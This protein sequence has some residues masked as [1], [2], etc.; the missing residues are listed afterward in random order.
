MPIGKRTKLIVRIMI[1]IILGIAISD[2]NQAMVSM[3]TNALAS[4]AGQVGVHL[5]DVEVGATIL[6]LCP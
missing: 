4:F 1:V 5:A 3:I 2:L 6:I